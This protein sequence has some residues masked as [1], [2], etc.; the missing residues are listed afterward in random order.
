MDKKVAVATKGKEDAL[1]WKPLN[2]TIRSTRGD[3]FEF[4]AL[5]DTYGRRSYSILKARDVPR[6]NGHLLHLPA[7]LCWELQVQLKSSQHGLAQV[8]LLFYYLY[9]L[10]S[11]CTYVLNLPNLET[12]Y[13]SIKGKAE[14]LARSLGASFFF[15]TE[16][17]VVLV[18]THLFP[19]FQRYFSN[20]W[21]FLDLWALKD[22][23]IRTIRINIC[24]YACMKGVGQDSSCP[25]T[26]TFKLY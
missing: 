9:S 17:V 8:L 23:P 12:K 1:L 7:L 19:A 13:Q 26:E 20:M 14:G 11:L 24:I 3:D 25:C 2:K 15:A 5:S 16:I 21:I 6:K 22:L 18:R 10:F 4:N